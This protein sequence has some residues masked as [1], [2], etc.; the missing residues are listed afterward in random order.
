MIAWQWAEAYPDAM[1]GRRQST[2][3]LDAGYRQN[4]APAFAEP[5]PS[6]AWLLAISRR[7]TVSPSSRK[8]RFSPVAS[9]TGSSTGAA[10]VEREFDLRRLR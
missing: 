6:E 2:C 1:D 4:L 8:E 10:P 7:A 5:D 3:G 9:S